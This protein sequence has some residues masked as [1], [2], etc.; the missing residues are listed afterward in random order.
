[1][2]WLKNLNE[3]GHCLLTG[4]PPQKNE[5]DKVRIHTALL[6]TI[7]TQCFFMCVYVCMCVYPMHEHNVWESVIFGEQH[8]HLSVLCAA[9]G[10]AVHNGYKPDTGYS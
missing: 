7:L 10:L 3:Y 8:G 9:A 5:M 1:M 4:L 6:F 2:R